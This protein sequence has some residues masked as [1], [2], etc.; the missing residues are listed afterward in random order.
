MRKV[1]LRAFGFAEFARASVEESWLKEDEELFAKS[2]AGIANG[3]A[4]PLW[5]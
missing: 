5:V 2:W 3:A 4:F 1:S